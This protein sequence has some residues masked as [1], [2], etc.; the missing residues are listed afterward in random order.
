[1][2]LDVGV[3]LA[4]AWRGHIHHRDGAAWFD[5]TSEDLVLCR[6]TQMGLLR[7]LSSPAVMGIEVLTRAQ[8]WQVIDALRR[9]ERVLA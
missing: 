3:W 4:V 7:L 1:M 5:E 9:D 2:L 6:M 8:A